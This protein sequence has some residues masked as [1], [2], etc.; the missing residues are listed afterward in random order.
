LPAWLT[1]A[2]RKKLSCYI[3]NIVWRWIDRALKPIE[4]VP[5][6]DL[7][8]PEIGQRNP[9]TLVFDL[10]QEVREWARIGLAASKKL[11]LFNF[12]FAGDS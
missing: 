6:G 11:H 2:S 3:N 7:K 5:A 1:P 8:T 10:A 4:W 9:Q 12:V